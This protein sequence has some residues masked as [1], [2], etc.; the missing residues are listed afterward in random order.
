MPFWLL[1]LTLPAFFMTDAH[2]TRRTCRQAWEQRE[3]RREFHA[4]AWTW[5][6]VRNRPDMELCIGDDDF[7]RIY[8]DWIY[9]YEDAVCPAMPVDLRRLIR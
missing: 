5:G 4:L 7:D 6:C 2:L 9:Q 8:L 1:V 3:A